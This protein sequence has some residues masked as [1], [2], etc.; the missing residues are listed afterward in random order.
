MAIV[1]FSG[2]TLSFNAF[3][4]NNINH[5]AQVSTSSGHYSWKTTSNFTI[6]ALSPF[7]NITAN[8]GGPT[9]GSIS[10]VNVVGLGFNPIFSITGL[11]APLTSL[12]V[13]GNAVASH[14][15]FWETVLAGA[16]TFVMPQLAGVAASIF[17]GDFVT[18][19]SGQ[20]LNGANDLFAG[21]GSPTQHIAVGDASVVAA[22]AR[23]NGGDDQFINLS[24]YMIGDVGSGGVPGNLGIVK[25]GND[26]FIGNGNPL[27]PTLAIEVAVGDVM[28]NNFG[29]SGGADNFKFTNLRAE[30]NRSSGTPFSNDGAAL[31][32]RA[33]HDDHR[34]APKVAE[35]FGVA[36]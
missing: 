5:N 33:D 27:A 31:S 9:G 1:D 8:G 17:G 22:N 15:H 28:Q 20:I 4:P 12:V 21:I 19:N 25:G 26:S 35:C 13:P 34:K 11:S 16:T 29:V 6:T 30:S 23:L 14:E 36:R 10:T 24:G 7:N 2:A 3:D 18:V 32:Q